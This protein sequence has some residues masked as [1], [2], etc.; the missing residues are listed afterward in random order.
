MILV[1]AMTKMLDALSASGK[2]TK[3]Q[4]QTAQ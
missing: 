4:T 2:N 1:E 3:K